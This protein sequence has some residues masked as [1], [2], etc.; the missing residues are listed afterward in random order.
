MK[1][2]DIHLRDP[3]IFPWQG[4][5]YLY[6]SRCRTL[7][8][9]SPVLGFDVYTGTDLENWSEATECFTPSAD[10][11]ADRQ[12][13][14]PEVHFYR[15]AFYLFVSFKSA[16]RH[17]GT[18]ILRAESPMG[19]FVPISEG[20]V[21][22]P[23]WES[24]DGTLFTDENGAPWMVFCNEWVQVT[25]GTVCALPL[26]A[27][28]TAAAGEPVKLFSAHESAWARTISSGSGQEGYVTDGP[29]LY[30]LKTG[31]LAMLWSSFGANCQ[32]AQAVA[33]SESGCLAGPWRHPQQPLFA[34]NGGHGMLFR[35]FEGE[36]YLVLHCPNDQPAERPC[37]LKVR[38][39]ADGLELA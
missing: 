9:K 1:L 10:F 21:T 22:P 20:P 32:Y 33:Y 5:Y 38:E 30:R 18:Q 16:T 37:L 15:N 14:A 34:Q 31:A 23:E 26:A 24:I 35:T 29:F 7:Q 36:L 4:V 17:R 28:L 2:K 27:D 12:Y 6:G 19:P 11:W 8:G 13:F 25:D 3:F 39:T